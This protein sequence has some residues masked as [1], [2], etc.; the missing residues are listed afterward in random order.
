MKDSDLCNNVYIT[1]DLSYLQRQDERSFRARLRATNKV[2]QVPAGPVSTPYQK[3]H[4]MP[5]NGAGDGAEDAADSSQRVL[6]GASANEPAAP[7]PSS[8]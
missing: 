6:P 4:Q 8:L 5:S 2:I 3:S 1:S 7:T